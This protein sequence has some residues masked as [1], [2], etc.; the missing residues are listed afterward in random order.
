E[1]TTP[2]LPPPPRDAQNRSAFS[3]ASAR[4][5]RPSAVTTSALSTLSAARP[6]SRPS[7]PIPPPSVNPVTPTEFDEPDSGARPYADA[8]ASTSPHTAPGPTCATWRCGSTCTVF[9]DVVFSSSPS[10]QGT[11]VPWPVAWTANGT[12]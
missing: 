5:S 12:S 3:Y 11:C 1:V 10:S 7:Q 6:Y 2:K 9:I 8:A 4:T